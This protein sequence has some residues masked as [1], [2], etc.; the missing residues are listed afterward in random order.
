M[1][2]I[3]VALRRQVIERANGCCE[4][5]LVPDGISF[6]AHEIDH[7]IA[8]KHGGQSV[9]ENLAYACWRCNRHKGSDLTSLDPNTGLVVQLFHPRTQ[10]WTEYFRLDDA[11]IVPVSATGRATSALLQ[12]NQ[13]A[14]VSERVGMIAKGG[15][16]PQHRS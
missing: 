14:R 9:A 5:C 10:R 15:Y 11:L 13:P 12:F 3:S 6:Y 7:I 16:P 4:Y 1:A 2:S 8:E